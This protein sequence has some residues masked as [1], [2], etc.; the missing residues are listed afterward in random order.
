[1]TPR[2]AKLLA[3]NTERWR[4][5]QAKPSAL[6]TANVVAK[7]LCSPDAQA[8]YKRIESRTGVPWFV[9]AVIHEREAGG[10]WSANIANGEPFNRVTRLVPKGRGPFK[11]FE[12]AAYDALVNCP[13]YAA[14]WTDWTPGGALT[15]LEQ[16]NGLG[17]AR[18]GLPSPY[19][20]SGTDQYV[21]GKYVK[22]G[23][24][25]PDYVDQQLGCAVLFDAMNVYSAPSKLPMPPRAVKPGLGTAIAG[26]TAAAATG[27][28]SH[29]IGWPL[30]AVAGLVALIVVGIAIYAFMKRGK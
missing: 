6:R 25:A 28:A 16:Y 19:I 13:P 23:V 9:I 18:R 22:D 14:R 7:R 15:L 21:K 11:N 27:L 17:Y 2:I 5:H 3:A 12:D 20:W 29:S 24:F 1:M 10:K 30:W 26:G 8:I 4:K